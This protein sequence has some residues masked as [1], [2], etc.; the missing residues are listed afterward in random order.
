MPGRFGRGMGRCGPGIAVWGCG[1][2]SVVAE[3]RRQIR[4]LVGGV[5]GLR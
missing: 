3:S 2:G 4:L 1:C 5:N